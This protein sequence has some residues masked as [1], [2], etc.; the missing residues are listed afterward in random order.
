MN[1][2]MDIRGIKCDTPHCNYRDDTI[3]FEDY[4]NWINKPCPICGRNLLT[5]KEYEQCLRLFAIEKKVN[6]FMHKWRWINPIFYYNTI[7][8]RKPKIYE[9]TFNYP[10]RK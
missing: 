10:K 5:Q 3:Q 7:T 2:S 1:K 6:K 4:P 8:G 9:T